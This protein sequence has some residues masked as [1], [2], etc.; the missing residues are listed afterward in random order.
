MLTLL[1]L[2]SE[3][4]FE[5]KKVPDVAKI[6][7][8]LNLEG[9]AFQWHQYLAIEHEG[10]KLS[11]N[12]YMRE[13]KERFA[14]PEHEDPMESLFFLKQ[15]DSVNQYHKDFIKILNLLQVPTQHDLTIFL[16]NL[17]PDFTKNLE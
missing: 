2:S 12:D 10:R 16:T 6:S 13:M 14:C 9:D 3:Q 5:A 15:Q 4:H 1:N 11:C 17:K 8:M 7:G